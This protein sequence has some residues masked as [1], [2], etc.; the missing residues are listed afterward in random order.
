[1]DYLCIFVLVLIPKSKTHGHFKSD[2]AAGTT[3]AP[4]QQRYAL[5]G[6]PCARRA[7][8][9]PTTYKTSLHQ[10]KNCWILQYGVNI[11][12]IYINDSLVVW[13]SRLTIL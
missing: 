3:A 5:A 1:M 7:L 2:H 6:S 13:E 10:T 11:H 9:L 8:E 12:T 4:D